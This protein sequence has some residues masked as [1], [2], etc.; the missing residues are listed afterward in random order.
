MLDLL[1]AE[2]ERA[3]P[4]AHTPSS[5][6]VHPELCPGKQISSTAFETLDISFQDIPSISK[7]SKLSLLPEVRQGARGGGNQTF[8]AARG[9]RVTSNKEPPTSDILSILGER[10]LE[11]YIQRLTKRC[12]S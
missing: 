8:Q 5:S 3:G 12:D 7:K 2:L 6:Q 11:C 1:W 10:S 4:L 9:L